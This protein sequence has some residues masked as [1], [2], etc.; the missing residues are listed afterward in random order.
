MDE[1]QLQKI[2]N[3]VPAPGNDG[4][5][6]EGIL[7]RVGRARRR[8]LVVRAATAL[9]VIIAVGFG[10][11][12]LFEAL[13]P[14]GQ[15]VITDDDVTDADGPGGSGTA[16]QQLPAEIRALRDDWQAGRIEIDWPPAPYDEP[17]ASLAWMSLDELFGWME[18]MALSPEVTAYLRDD[19]DSE[20]LLT[21]IRSWPEVTAAR[22]V[23]RDE[24]LARLLEDVENPEILSNLPTNPLPNSIEIAVG[25]QDAASVVGERLQARPEVDEARW[26]ADTSRAA[27]GALVWLRTHAHP[28]GEG[29][30][31]EDPATGDYLRITGQS[32]GEA[33]VE[34]AGLMLQNQFFPALLQGD[35]ER[36]RSMLVA[37]R[38]GEASALLKDAQAH[39]E[40]A[41]P[42]AVSGGSFRPL[43]WT[44]EKYAWDPPLPVPSG[45]DTWIKEHPE[46]RLG[47]QVI[48]GDNVLWWF[49]MER[50]VDVPW[51]VWPGPRDEEYRNTH[52]LAE[53]Q[54]L[55]LEATPRPG[56]HVQFRLR[57]I[58]DSAS[59]SADLVIENKSDSAFVLRAS[60]LGLVI[61]G[62]TPRF[63]SMPHSPGV[64]EV[65]PG[66][67]IGAGN[68]WMWGL[69][70]PTSTSTRLSYTPSDPESE[71]RTWVVQTPEPH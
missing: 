41:G 16:N 63:L 68:G 25:T 61:D 48:T 22:F 13:R 36:L 2:F 58:P 32:L 8:R 12:Q 64:L 66:E 46:S 24:A 67:T 55:V 49:G 19:A 56:V 71:K 34:T 47:F 60:D 59:V 42:E 54:S 35:L 39:V 29:T 3:R 62:A 5:A 27:E 37:E 51:L 31:S 14:P 33:D 9:V 1:R 7:E 17:M 28:A 70:G 23:S 6:L 65:G 11:F 10:S 45:L 44:G 40:S 38:R 21:A 53:L 69:D 57:Q 4:A 15:L 50:F 20:P 18:D 43:V 52:T 30:G 26:S